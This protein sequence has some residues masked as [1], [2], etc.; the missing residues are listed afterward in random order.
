[1]LLLQQYFFKLVFHRVKFS[2]KI[3]YYYGGTKHFKYVS[4]GHFRVFSFQPSFFFYR[5]LFRFKIQLGIRQHA[6][7]C[8]PKTQGSMGNVECHHFSATTVTTSLHN[9]VYK[10]VYRGKTILYTTCA[11]LSE[12]CTTRIT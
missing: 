7:V 8:C 10:R 4:Y 1:M 5:C 11:Q 3:C 9:R 6:F 12:R 2:L